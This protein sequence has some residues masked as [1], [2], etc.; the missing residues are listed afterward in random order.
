MKPLI[1]IP[2]RYASTRFPGKPLAL[3]GGVPMVERTARIAQAVCET[4]PAT[5]YVVATDDE[6]IETVVRVCEDAEFRL[7]LHVDTSEFV[8]A[9]RCGQGIVGSGRHYA[10]IDSSAHR[11]VPLIGQ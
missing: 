10:V 8:S 3:I 9:F 4:H 7:M 2:A 1:V 5:D 6:R 11:S